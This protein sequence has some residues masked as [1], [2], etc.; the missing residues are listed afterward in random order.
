MVSRKVGSIAVH[1]TLL[2]LFAL[3][4]IGNA[5]RPASKTGAPN[6]LP[7]KSAGVLMPDFFKAITDAGVLL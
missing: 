7:F 1:V 5:R 3:A 4:K 6:F 2:T